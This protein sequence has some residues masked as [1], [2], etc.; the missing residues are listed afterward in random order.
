MACV[1]TVPYGF[2]GPRPGC[3][4]WA[5]KCCLT[6]LTYIY[7]GVGRA[8]YLTSHSAWAR[9]RALGPGV[10]FRKFQGKSASS[11]KSASHKERL[12]AV[13]LLYRYVLTQRGKLM[14]GDQQMSA[15]TDIIRAALML[16]HNDRVV[17]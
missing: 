12:N 16:R 2:T 11:E 14:F 15:L 9:A 10:D 1:S 5:P 4:L 6:H 17:G 8:L 7:I 13:A 3:G